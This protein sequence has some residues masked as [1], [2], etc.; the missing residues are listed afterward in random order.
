MLLEYRPDVDAKDK[1]GGT[2]L[3]RATWNGHEATVQVL[4]KHR[5]DVDAKDKSDGAAA[6]G[7]KRDET[8]V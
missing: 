5:A 3:R 7:L 2:A 6:G 1:F 8:T 4:L